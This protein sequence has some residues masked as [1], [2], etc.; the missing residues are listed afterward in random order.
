VTYPTRWGSCPYVSFGKTIINET[1]ADRWV[2]KFGPTPWPALSPDLTICD[3]ALWGIVKSR[4]I[5]QKPQNVEALKDVI[6]DVFSNITTVQLKAI[7]E[8]NF[9]RLQLCVEIG[10]KQVDPYD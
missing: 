8:R 2:S 7:N 5:G 3:N 10:G 6:T 1:F 9:R 4:V